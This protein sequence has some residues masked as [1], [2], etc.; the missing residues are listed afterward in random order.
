MANPKE[1]G[2]YVDREQIAFVE[3]TSETVGTPLNL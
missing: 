1:Y 2:Y 3:K